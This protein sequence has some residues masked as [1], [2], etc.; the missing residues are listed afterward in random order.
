[1]NDAG[2]PRLGHL[3]RGPHQP[4]RILGFYHLLAALGDARKHPVNVELVPDI[5]PEAEAV[6]VGRENEQRNVVLLRGPCAEHGI[7]YARPDMK[8][9]TTKFAG[10]SRIYV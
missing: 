2:K 4:A 3:H 7:G 9:R 5:A 10:G 8:Q 1:M 6:E